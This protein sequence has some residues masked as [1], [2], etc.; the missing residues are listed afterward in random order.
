MRHFIVLRLL[1]LV[2]VL[3]MP[4][5]R[6]DKSSASYDLFDADAM[7]PK[8]QAKIHEETK[9]FR[10]P[11]ELDDWMRLKLQSTPKWRE[12]FRTDLED[13]RTPSGEAMSAATQRRLQSE[14]EAYILHPAFVPACREVTSN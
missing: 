1:A 6:A 12:K 8:I 14:Y 2:A 10:S 9:D 13:Y 7:D 3:V 11:E 5:A 4:M